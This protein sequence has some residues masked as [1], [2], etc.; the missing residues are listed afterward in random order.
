MHQ[1]TGRW[2]AVAGLAVAPGAWA[3]AASEPAK[4]A[5]LVLVGQVERFNIGQA[6]FCGPRTEIDK[7]T[8]VAFE[9][10]AERQTHFHI[11]TVIQRGSQPVVCAGDYH[12]VPGTGVLHI[13]RA[14]PQGDSC[15]LEMFRSYP[16]GRPR[17]V[18]LNT[19]ATRDCPRADAPAAASGPAAR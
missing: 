9:V 13:I 16:G 4:L 17:R 10:P 19:A 7:P 2:L 11:R 14:T 6:G 5:H 3:Q 12:F 8:S 1:E 15:V 18:E